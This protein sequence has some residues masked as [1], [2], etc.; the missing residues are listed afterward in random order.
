MTART[1]T[2]D[3][4]FKKEIDR[5]A[6]LHGHLGPFLVIGIRMG[7]IAKRQLKADNKGSQFQVMM[8]VPQ[9][10]PFTCTIDGVQAYT[11]CTIGNQRLAVEKSDT[12]ISC[13]FRLQDSKQTVEITLKPEVIE[14]LMNQFKDRVKSEELAKRVALMTNEEL[15]TVEVH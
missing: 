2:V 3:R 5:A 4:A 15:F 8:R 7:K 13:S 9:K 12:E 10:T 6:A 1:L 14:D 11:H